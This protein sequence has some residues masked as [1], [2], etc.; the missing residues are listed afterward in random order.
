MLTFSPFLRFLRLTSFKV[1]G[2]SSTEKILSLMLATV[3]LT[4]F[5]AIE[6]L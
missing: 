2:I 1:E 3:R 6:P 4:P 5:T